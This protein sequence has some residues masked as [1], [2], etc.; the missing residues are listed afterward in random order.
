M[1]TQELKIGEGSL[2]YDRVGMMEIVH[3]FII[4]SNK[5]SILFVY[6]Q[7]E[8]KF[9]SASYINH[10]EKTMSF[11]VEP[12]DHSLFEICCINKECKLRLFDV[13]V[14]TEIR[15]DYDGYDQEEVTDVVVIEKYNVSFDRDWFRSISN[16]RDTPDI[17][18]FVSA[19]LIPLDLPETNF[20]YYN[21]NEIAEVMKEFF[22][23]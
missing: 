2:R 23:M 1:F 15:V 13:H 14:K 16:D 9:V 8:R 20:P 3:P 21:T 18:G 7:I 6:D 22:E 19:Y 10:E 4:D 12:N 5:I 17:I 11:E